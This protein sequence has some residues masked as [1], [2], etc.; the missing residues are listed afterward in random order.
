MILTS[1]TTPTNDIIVWKCQEEIWKLDII[2]NV[3]VKYEMDYWRKR[4]RGNMKM[5]IIG[6]NASGGNMK[7]DILEVMLQG[8]MKNDIVM[9]TL[10]I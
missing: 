10:E 3:S 6:G 8:N 2:G 1:F 4:L 9:E 7:M 5:D